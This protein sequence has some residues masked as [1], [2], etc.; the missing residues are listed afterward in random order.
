M[1]QFSGF[2]AKMDF[3]PIPNIFFSSVLPEISDIHELKVILHIL[4][5]LYRK[6][7]HP[8][9]LTYGELLGNVNLLSSL[10]ELTESPD[11]VLKKVLRS[12]TERF[13]ILHVSMNKA[14]VSED[15][16]FL[17]TGDNRDIVEKINRGEYELSGF[18]LGEQVYFEKE[19]E[20]EKIPDIF[21]LYEQNIGMLTPMIAEELRDAEKVYPGSWIREAIKKAINQNKR[22]W[23]YI[24]AILGNWATEGRSDGSYQRDSKKDPDKYVKGKYG[25]MVRR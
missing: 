24:S 4:A 23:S 17:N 10:K 14:G 12:A 7:G 6:R 8:R 22:K 5:V 9:F 25:H 3:T 11:E 13:V 16:Y 18:K 19:I 2:P 15:V 1:R 20:K 21:A